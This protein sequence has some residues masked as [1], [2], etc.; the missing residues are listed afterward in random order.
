MTTFEVWISSGA[1]LNKCHLVLETL[2][3][4]GNVSEVLLIITFRQHK[5]Q[6]YFL[7]TSGC[8][9]LTRDRYQ[10]LKYLTSK[11]A[12]KR[13]DRWHLHIKRWTF[14]SVTLLSYA[15]YRISILAYVQTRQGATTSVFIFLLLNMSTRSSGISTSMRFLISSTSSQTTPSSRTWQN[16]Q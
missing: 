4:W 11:T 1:G 9:N 13:E 2:V 15:K 10:V 12:S 3:T 5:N 6:E 8:L 16:N 7:F 14:N